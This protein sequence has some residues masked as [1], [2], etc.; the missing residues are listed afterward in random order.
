MDP[1]EESFVGLLVSN[2]RDIVET[3]K[4]GKYS[5][6]KLEGRI[7]FA[8]KPAAYQFPGDK[9]FQPSFYQIGDSETFDIPLLPSPDENKYSLVLMGDPQVYAQDQIN[10]LGEV[11]TD[12][13]YGADYEFMIVLGDL[14]GNTLPILPKVKTTLGLAGK[15]SYYALGNHDRDRGDFPDPTTGDGSSLPG[16]SRPSTRRVRCSASR[17]ASSER[18]T[19]RPGAVPR[20]SA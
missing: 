1:G 12:E 11:A 20:P 8:I 5:I 4:K 16:S 14:V 18:P 19:R 3:N 7:V 2:G 6:E 17:A 15:T 13:L 9:D 10:Y